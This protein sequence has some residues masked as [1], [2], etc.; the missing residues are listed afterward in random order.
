MS[1]EKKDVDSDVIEIV[2]GREMIFVKWMIE[3]WGVDVD[4]GER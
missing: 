2:M 4:G 3:R 1:K